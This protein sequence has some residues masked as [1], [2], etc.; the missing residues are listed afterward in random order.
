MLFFHR[1]FVERFSVSSSLSFS[2]TLRKQTNRTNIVQDLI[3]VLLHDKFNGHL[4]AI[5]NYMFEIVRVILIVIF[6]LRREHREWGRLK[7]TSSV[8]VR[9]K[10]LINFD[11]RIRESE[12]YGLS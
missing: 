8:L 6:G 7:C 2:S 4:I 9:G 10:L 1:A 12:L 11:L 5:L 3:D